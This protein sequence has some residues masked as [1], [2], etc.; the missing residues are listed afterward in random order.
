MQHQPTGSYAQVGS[1]PLQMGSPYSC[2]SP[3]SQVYSPEHFDTQIPPHGS[4]PYH[5]SPSP[6]QSTI[7]SPGQYS[8][9]NGTTPSPTYSAMDAVEGGVPPLIPFTSAV[10]T[11]CGGGVPTVF[12]TATSDFATYTVPHVHP[13][14]VEA[15]VSHQAH[16]APFQHMFE[17]H[18]HHER[19]SSPESLCSG[20][21][22]PLAIKQMS[23]EFGIG[24]IEFYHPPTP[25]NVVDGPPN[26]MYHHEMCG[27][28]PMPPH[29]EMCGLLTPLPNHLCPIP[30]LGT[31]GRKSES[32]T[33]T[34]TSNYPLHTYGISYH[35]HTIEFYRHLSPLYRT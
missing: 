34:H 30:T 8:G 24:G 11:T 10:T 22:A 3:E 15:Y 6:Y 1:P 35:I 28:G 7:Q 21:S 25:P 12:N 5:P 33:H 17:S 9:H 18:L 16:L 27:P 14:M 26:M 20:D 2:S 13:H 32:H 4:P 31:H 23:N 19:H 29:P